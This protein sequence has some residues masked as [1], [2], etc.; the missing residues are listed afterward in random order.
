MRTLK[1]VLL[2]VI[3][4]AV[5]LIMAANMATVELNLLPGALAADGWSVMAPLAG[6]IVVSVLTG[7]LLGFLIEYLREAKHRRS[8][9]EKRSQIAQLKAE[10]ARLAKQAGVD[11]DDLPGLVG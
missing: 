6:V 2:I 7:V 3:S 10:N 1:S 11:A 4:V 5:M 8:L 9:T